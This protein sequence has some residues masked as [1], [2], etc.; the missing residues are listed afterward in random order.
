MPNTTYNLLDDDGLLYAVQYIFTKLK[1]S[2][3]N[4]NTTYSV[5]LDTTNERIV[6]TGSD[7]STTYVS[8]SDFGEDN[9]IETVKVN[10]TALT[11]DANKAVNVSVPTKTS[12]ITN[13]SNFVSDASYVHTDN[14]YTTTEKNK[15]SGIAAGAQVNKIETVKVNGTALTITSKAVDIPAAGATIKGVISNADV[16]TLIQAALAGFERISFQKVNSYSD[17]PATGQNGVIYLVPISGA[18]VPN[19]YDEYIWYTDSST[20]PATSGYEK[21]GTTAIDLSG[22]VQYTDISLITNQEI[23]DIVDDAY[24]AVFNPSTP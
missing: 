9:V 22:Y 11:P 13:D 6:L 20:T 18:Q 17:L 24:D 19:I 14:N 7:S 1:T 3:L 4:V 10:G 23:T 12:N 2:P 8:Y 15:L 16:N 21:I 5:S